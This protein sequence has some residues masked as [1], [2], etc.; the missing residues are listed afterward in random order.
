MHRVPWILWAALV[1][2]A[3]GC[4]EKAPSQAVAGADAIADSGATADTATDVQPETAADTQPAGDTAADTTA[5]TTGDTAADAVADAVADGA[6]D[7]AA[8]TGAET[9]ADT[10]PDTAPDTAADTGAAGDAAPDGTSDAVPE[11]VLCAASNPKFPAFAKACGADADCFVAIHQVD[12][13][14]TKAAMGLAS[15]QKA[16]FAAAEALCEQQF[17]DCKCAQ[18]PTVAE[19]GYTAS[20]SAFKAVCQAGLCKATVA[21]PVAECTSSGLVWPKP[22]KHCAAKT[23][24]TYV[25]RTIDCCGSQLATGIVKTAKDAY[26]AKEFQCA[27][28]MAI[29]DCMAMPLKM[30]DGSSGGDGMVAVD[31]VQ[32]HCQTYAKP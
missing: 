14:G 30:E 29:C 25:L 24:C 10:A 27:K 15:S 5:D 23:D 13:C 16:A 2:A 18:Q 12:C 31:C 21:N 20:D 22:V 4:G 7:A 1:S 3:G 11:G 6:A 8:D 17:P 19:D 9:A 32:G 26:E 28:S